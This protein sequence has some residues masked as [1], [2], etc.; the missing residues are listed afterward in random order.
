MEGPLAALLAA[1]DLVPAGRDRFDATS[2]ERARPRMFGG[3]LVAQALVAAARTAPGRACHSIHAHFVR[4]GDP[5]Q[6]LRL[7]VRRVRDGQRFALRQVVTSQGG[8]EVLLSTVSLAAAAGEPFAFQQ[9]PMPEVPGPDGLASELEQRL[10]VRDR[11]P[12][13]ARAWLLAPRAV[14]IRQVRPV[15]LVDPPPVEPVA[16]AWLRTVGR[17]PDDPALHA[18]VLAYASDTTLLDIGCYPHG[19]SWIDPRM[20]QASL[21]HAMWFHRPFRADEWLLHAQVAPSLAAGRAFT[22]GSVFTAGGVLVASVAQEGV[23]RRRTAASEES[24]R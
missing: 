24:G 15:P 8:R 10:A 13:G 11:L 12:A 19:L 6:P 9:E 5:Q 4:P 16:H 2:V 21:D 7:D 14:E 18:A 1:L 22:R 3:E 20:E 17:L 23:S